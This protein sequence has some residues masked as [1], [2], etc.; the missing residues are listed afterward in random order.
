M[1]TTDSAHPQLPRRAEVYERFFDD[2]YHMGRPAEIFEAAP[3]IQ[4]KARLVGPQR[5]PRRLLQHTRSHRRI[6]AR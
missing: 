4:G 1:H 3:S 6:V 5:S 2:L